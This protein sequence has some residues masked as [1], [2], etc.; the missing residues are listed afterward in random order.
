MDFSDGQCAVSVRSV[1][2]RRHLAAA[3]EVVVAPCCAT[4]LVRLLLSGQAVTNLNDGKY[5]GVAEKGYEADE[6]MKE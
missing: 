1:P 5:Q 2:G 6:E 3:A 4:R